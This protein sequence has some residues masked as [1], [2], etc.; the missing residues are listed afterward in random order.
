MKRFQLVFAFAVSLS[1]H[2]AV[3]RAAEPFVKLFDGETLKGWKGKSELWSVRDGAIVGNS[4]P[5]GIRGNTFLVSEKEYDN[6][7]LRLKFKFTDGNSGV[8]VRSQQVGNPAGY[9]IKGYQADIGEG[10]HGSLYDEKRRGM[11]AKSRLDWVL[12]FLKKNEWNTYEIRCIGKQITL[13]INRLVTARYTEEDDGIPRRGVIALQLHGTPPPGMEILFKEIEIREIKPKRVLFTTH[14]ADFPHRSR[15][16]AREIL[17]K[18]GRD[19][20]YF[21][22]VVT[23]T[24]DLITPEGLKDFDAVGFYTTGGLGKFPLSQENR[25]YLIEWVK[26]GHTFFGT[27]SATDTYGDWQPYW[28]M[29]GGTFAGHPWNDGSPPVTIDVEDPTHPSAHHLG[30]QWVIQDE[31]YQFKNYSRDRIHV[32][33]SLNPKEHKKGTTPHGDYPVAWCRDFGEGKV[34][35]T[36]LGHREDV[37]TNPV[38]QQHLMA[39]VLWALGIPGYEGSAKPGRPKPGNDWGSLFDGKTLSGWE[40]IGEARWTVGEGGILQG[41]GPRG[42][43]FSPGEYGNFH[44]KATV[45]VGDD[46]NSG[47]YFRTLME[48]GRAWPQGM[49]AQVNSTHGDPLR[50]GTL[51]GYEAV[52]EQLAKPW[53]WFTQEVIAVDEYVVIKVNGRVTVK[54]Q[55]PFAGKHFPKGR[56]AFQQHHPGSEVDYKDV[57]VRQLP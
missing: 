38:Y 55:V 35:Y 20:G 54:R 50:T 22:A 32:I 4:R 41:R 47:M 49:E 56:F 29:I 24:V 27:H 14:A 18:I 19:S 1:V 23:D 28:E 5:N 25:E 46:S 57:V 2:P 12:R 15:P 53:E 34:F 37:W 3:V 21:E 30:S 44:Y 26:Q 7:I 40:G 45:R 8:Q 13:K 10:Y 33:L 9:V 6:F 36:S 16:K 42:H 17:Q 52:Y 31:I 11:L 51:Y 48:A 39:G 43:L